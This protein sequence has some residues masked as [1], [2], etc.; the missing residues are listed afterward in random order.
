MDVPLVE[1]LPLSEACLKGPF[2]NQEQISYIL[3]FL[4]ESIGAILWIGLGKEFV[5]LLNLFFQLSVFGVI[6]K[7]AHQVGWY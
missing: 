5:F 4:Q 6:K 7:L 2:F 3:S 1:T